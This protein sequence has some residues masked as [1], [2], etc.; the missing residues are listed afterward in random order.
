MSETEKDASL[1][2]GGLVPRPA[3]HEKNSK[4]VAKRGTRKNCGVLGKRKNYAWKLIMKMLGGTTAWLQQ[5][6]VKKNEPNSYEI[7]IDELETFNSKIIELTSE[8]NPIKAKNKK[9]K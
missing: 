5:F 7:P 8:R 6:E 4:W 9:Y 2:A 3:P 1:K